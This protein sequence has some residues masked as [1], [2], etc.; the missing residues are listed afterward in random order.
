[1]NLDQYPA[2]IGRQTR[3]SQRA[4]VADNI[5]SFTRRRTTIPVPA[6]NHPLSPYHNTLPATP[7]RRTIPFG[8]LHTPT[9][10]T[11]INTQVANEYG[12][13]NPFVDQPNLY[14]SPPIREE[15][16]TRNSLPSSPLSDDSQQGAFLANQKRLTN[17]LE[18]LSDRLTIQHTPQ[19]APTT[20]RAKPRAP[21]VFDGSDQSKID[22]FILQCS[23]YCA[24]R[25]SDFPDETAKVSFMLSYLKGSPLDWFQTELSQA[26]TGYGPTPAWFTSV[27]TFTEDLYR[28]F[29]PRDPITDATIALENLRYRDS[30]KAVKYSLDFNRHARKT[31]WNEAALVRCFYKGLPDRMKDEIARVGKPT[32][33]IQLQNLVQ[34]LDQRHWERQSEISRDKRNHPA[35]ASTY[36][37]S[38]SYQARAPDSAPSASAKKSSITNKLGSD[39]KLSKAERDR[40]FEK[41]LCLGCGEAGHRVNA[42]RTINQKR[43]PVAKG[44]ASTAEAATPAPS[45]DKSVQGKE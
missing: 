43:R 33:L 15:P 13:N 22:T 42:C 1:M 23:M 45:T 8:I 26:M 20:S 2:P 9:R 14:R 6:E 35:P 3:N 32:D 37:P 36:K 28:L 40:R 44:K 21:D 30:S 27:A 41:D 34:V 18:S 39:G 24:L 12:E 19:Q 29:G 31:G 38:A 5:L 11:A 16:T 17:I 10:P 25:S 7:I 4:G